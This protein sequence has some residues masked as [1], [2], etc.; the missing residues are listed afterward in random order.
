MLFLILEQKSFYFKTEAFSFFFL[1][2]NMPY[3]PDTP[4]SH[5]SYINYNFY[6]KSLLFHKENKM[7]ITVNNLS[8]LRD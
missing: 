7:V 1:N 2:Q 8:F 6:A 5:K 4:S 3:Y